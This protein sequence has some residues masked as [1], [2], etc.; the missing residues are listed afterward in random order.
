[1]QLDV[2]T[3]W[4]VIFSENPNVGLFGYQLG[5]AANWHIA[6]PEDFAN[7]GAFLTNR[8]EGARLFTLLETSYRNCCRVAPTVPSPQP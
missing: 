3:A 5:L 8:K 1:L 7:E 6:D 2:F 4:Q